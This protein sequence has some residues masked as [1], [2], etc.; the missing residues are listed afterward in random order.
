MNSANV[1]TSAYSTGTLRGGT[2]ADTPLRS[3]WLVSVLTL[4]MSCTSA[5]A[6]SPVLASVLPR[7]GQRGGEI[8]LIFQGDRLSDA[9]EILLYRPGLSIGK[10]EAASPQQLKVRVKIAADAP[11]GEHAM[12]VRTAT[13]VSELRTFW[14]GALPVTPE[15]EPNSDFASPQKISLNCTV[16]GVIENED[17]DY[18]AVELEQGQRL[19][20]EV[21]AMR[22]GG[23][24]FDP[25]IAILDT[26]RYELA[27]TD[28][29]AL[30]LQ[31]SVAQIVAP[32][33]GTYIVQVR[34]SSYRGGGD[35]RYRLHVGTFPRPRT[36][37][38]AGGQAGGELDVTYL[39]DVAG[40]IK[41]ALK[42]P[43]ERRDDHPLLV[44]QN[45]QVTPSPVHFRVSPFPNV[46]EAEPNDDA[47]TAS[48]AAGDVPLGLNGVI[49]K[50]GDVDF[51]KFHAKKDQALDIHVY[52]RRVRSPLDPLMDLC[53]GN[54]K[55]IASNDDAV[56]PDSYL[57]WQVPAD[58]DYLVDVRDHLREGGPDYVYRIEI[59]PVAPSIGV[60]IPLV[61]AN[62]QERQAL[63]VPKGNRY[64]TLVRAV[65]SDVGGE[66]LISADGLPEGVSL[67]AGPMAANA[68]VVPVVFEATPTA[69]TA[70]RICDLRAAPVDP[71]TKAASVFSQAADLV[72]GANQVAFYQ[73]KVNKLAVAVAEEVPFKLE[74]VQ[75][76]IPLVQNG[77]M[78][79]KVVAERKTGF[80]GSIHLKL[81]FAPPGVGAGELDIPGDKSEALLQINAASDAQVGKWKICMLGSADVGGQVWVSSGL[82]DL[83]I[84]PP[85]VAMKLDMAATE[86]GK[87]AQVLCRIEQH[88]KFAGS[89]TVK[90][91]G[92]P[93]NASAADLTI[94]ESDPQCVFTVTTDAK[95]PVGQHNSLFCS[96]SIP[97]D[98]EAIVQSTG[99]GGVLR[100]D[101][102]PP[103]PVSAPAAPPA[104]PEPGNQQPV[105]SRLEKL[106]QEQAHKSPPK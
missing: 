22:L 80:T 7:G 51:F 37:Y 33:P 5:F 89:A 95:T 90:L 62:S 45:G 10:I 44:E 36:V 97:R 64:A 82:V 1:E 12:R 85:L 29:T 43:P 98:G 57:R 92:L 49:T 58:G 38:P 52:A 59:T 8:D 39:G 34:E 20:V 53:D 102:P 63:V 11:L 60:S 21:E 75:P 32:K 87:P 96:V 81:P 40:A 56:G 94:T 28:D 67:T 26:A 50:P 68:D 71:N 41:Q 100:V 99:M 2:S 25:Y 19:T 27:A 24:L 18:Y 84:A 61:S 42:V 55:L 77:Q 104:P 106:R 13:G 69:P 65:R 70:G 93:P 6:A 3:L 30:L 86:Q 91:L 47:K 31:D 74:L 9:Q 4:A 72:V 16:E 88:G 35:Y 105:L 48:V 17:V 79:L 46:L 54:G 101:A 23:P 15:V 66:L 103:A 83:E 73:A 14:V 78:Q 76:K